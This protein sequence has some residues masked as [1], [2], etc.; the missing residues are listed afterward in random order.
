M[1]KLSTEKHEFR[2]KGCSRLYIPGLTNCCEKL[3]HVTAQGARFINYSLC[4]AHVLMVTDEKR[5][6][7]SDG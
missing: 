2:C 3:V 1:S 5:R 6:P 4:P 7:F